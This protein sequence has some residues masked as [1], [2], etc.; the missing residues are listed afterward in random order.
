LFACWSVKGGSGTTVVAAALAVTLG[1]RH[2][3]GALLVDLAGD[4]PAALG[5]RPPEGPGLAEWLEAG[6]RAPADAL[7]RL[8]VPV[9]DRLRLLPRGHVSWPDDA[10]ADLVPSVL[11]RDDRIVVVDCGTLALE[12]PAEVALATVACATH[13]LLVV[14][15]CYLALRR[16]Q[17]ALVRPS[18]VI[19]VS[20]PGRALDAMDVEK[21]L[22][23]PVLAE[24]PFDPAVAR[25]VDAGL[26]VERVP[27]AMRQALGRAA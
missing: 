11:A 27:R 12:M 9:R 26:L 3:R 8:E 17:L 1:R 5:M 15:P 16:A 7:S 20:E 4:L 6:S 14:R 24:L 22:G 23:V 13:S 18:Q 25:A 10:E 21:V 2:R 19:V